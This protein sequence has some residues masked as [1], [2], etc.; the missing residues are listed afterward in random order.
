MWL[1]RDEGAGVVSTSYPQMLDDPMNNT[2]SFPTMGG[3]VDP[4]Y[5]YVV[6]ELVRVG[7][8]SHGP[9]GPARLNIQNIGGPGLG[10][11]SLMQ[12]NG[13]FPDKV[14]S[15]SGCDLEFHMMTNGIIAALGC[16]LLDLSSFGTL[17]IILSSLVDGGPIQNS[18]R[19][20]FLGGNTL[21]ISNNLY[22]GSTLA[23]SSAFC[24]LIFDGA[25]AFDAPGDAVDL[26]IGS[27]M[28]GFGGGMSG[29][30]HG[31]GNLTGCKV[32]PNST[33]SYDTAKSLPDITGATEVLVGSVATTWAAIDG[34]GG[35]IELAPPTLARV[36]RT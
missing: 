33:F 13:G 16:R 26:Q 8:V 19:Q 34:A 2:I 30:L 6:E 5:D 28:H 17:A 35:L 32:G 7:G 29:T 31:T 9:N 10:I 3:L 22:V 1:K 15:F 21:S 11:P 36:V 20:L 23:S 14:V 27:T 24:G 4:P 18:M 12:A 25:S